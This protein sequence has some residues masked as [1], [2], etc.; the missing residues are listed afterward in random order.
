MRNA[1]KCNSISHGWRRRTLVPCVVFNKAHLQWKASPR[2]LR[3]QTGTVC[4]P[5]SWGYNQK[6]RKLNTTTAHV[7]LFYGRLTTRVHAFTG[8]AHFATGTKC[9][10]GTTVPLLIPV[11]D[12][13]TTLANGNPRRGQLYPGG[14]RRKDKEGF[15]RFSRIPR[16]R[17]HY[18]DQRSCRIRSWPQSPAKTS[19]TVSKRRRS[20]ASCRGETQQSKDGENDCVGRHE[21]Q[22]VLEL[23]EWE[24]IRQ[25]SRNDDPE[26]RCLNLKTVRPLALFADA[27]RREPQDQP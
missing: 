19:K 6:P 13:G 5:R 9:F 11:N 3:E 26:K 18:P 23:D 2:G 12:C 15:R 22:R 7:S 25:D 1:G 20:T 27:E 21:A 16:N 24:E 4:T 10:R 14:G 8:V 17:Y